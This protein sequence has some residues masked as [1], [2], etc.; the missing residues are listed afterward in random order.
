M[1]QLRR[2]TPL[3]FLP[4]L[5]L[6]AGGCGDDDVP[7]RK[8]TTVCSFEL[9]DACVGVTQSRCSGADCTIGVSC[10]ATLNAA[11]DAELGS[12]L[13]AAQPG[14]CILLGPGDFGA[15]AVPS[16]VSLVGSGVDDTRVGGVQVA[17]GQAAVLRGLHVQGAGVV[18]D[19]ADDVRIDEVRISASGAH[20]LDVG[21]S[22]RALLVRS[23]VTSAALIGAQVADGSL[24]IVDSVIAEGAGPGV[25]ATCT[26]GCDCTADTALSIDSSLIIGNSHVG[27]FASGA[28]VE[29]TGSVIAE[30]EVLGLE[31]NSGGGVVA[32]ECSSLEVAGS[33]VRD[34]AYFGVLVDSSTGSLGKDG[35]EN[36]IIIYGNVMG[37]FLQGLGTLEESGFSVSNAVVEGNA[38][39]GLGIGGGAKG[40]IIYGTQI[41]KTSARTL[42]VAGGGAQEVGDGL[43]WAGTAQVSIDALGVSESARQGVLIDGPV[44]AGSAITNLTLAGGDE[45]KGLVQ[46]SVQSGDPAPTIGA[47]T[48]ALTTET[49]EVFVLP[50]PPVAPSP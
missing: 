16:G 22:R 3:A 49:A 40:I 14:D 9:H 8:P 32:A 17:S 33:E 12:A 15:I 11:S 46:Q 6:L 38:G 18:L 19:A 2:L 1:E 23:E 4:L 31:P 34:N 25:V 26:G 45:Q 30:T 47:G 7:E 13:G 5:A 29:V 21:A 36:G 44:A 35:E 20:G 50:Q 39:L 41:K 24:S 10:S 37:V 42:P 43:L 27:L 28:S 48:P